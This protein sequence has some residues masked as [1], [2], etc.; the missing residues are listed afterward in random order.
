MCREVEKIGMD[1]FC[2]WIDQQAEKK[3]HT[4]L[5]FS[6]PRNAPSKCFLGNPTLRLITPEA[7]GFETKK[8][9][10]KEDKNYA[11]VQTGQREEGRLFA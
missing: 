8:Q 2:V 3:V 7:V 6:I 5:L 9:I 4:L 11:K 1:Y 10:T